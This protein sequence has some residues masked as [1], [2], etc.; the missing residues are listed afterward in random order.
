MAVSRQAFRS[1]AGHA[2]FERGGNQVKNGS[3]AASLWG[4][5]LD[6]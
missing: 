4:A 6:R 5:V 2:M 1:Q 3:R